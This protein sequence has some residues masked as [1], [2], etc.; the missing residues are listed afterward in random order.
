MWPWGEEEQADDAAPATSSTAAAAAPPAAPATEARFTRSQAA[1]SPNTN[2][3][4]IPNRKETPREYLRRIKTPSP[5]AQ[6][7]PVF[8]F[9]QPTTMDETTIQRLME[10]AIRATQS[11][12]TQQVQSLKK[13]DLPA[14]DKR[15]IETWILRIESAYKRVNCVDPSLKFAHLETKFEVDQ[16]PV[17]DGFLYG[18]ATNENWTRFLTYLRTR[19]GKTTKEKTQ[20]L[21]RG[22]PR[23]GRTPSQLAAVIKEK[24]KDVTI[25]D[26]RKEQLLKQLPPQVLT[27]IVDKVDSLSFED[28][29]KLA[30]AWFDQ[31]GNLKLQTNTTS[32]NLVAP[33][34]T[35]R[36]QEPQRTAAQQETPQPTFS[37]PFIDEEE[38]DINAIR[39]RQ[40]QKQTYN[41]GNSRGRGRGTFSNRGSSNTNSYGSSSSYGSG[42]SFG[43]SSSNTNNNYGNT[44]AKPK[45]VCH[46][47]IKFGDKA[48]RCEDWCLL[49]PKKQQ[50]KG[51]ARH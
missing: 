18:D 6:Q 34:P 2:F 45:N 46:F 40:A 24:T 16:D 36:Q 4:S 1:S 39:A 50:G 20:L 22:I 49:N 37:Q 43:S 31:E 33:P 14:F 3:L 7:E 47:H 9:T 35:P 42:S 30:D 17:I 8:S 10:A 15:N 44:P 12:Q 29:A 13:P 41:R 48:E 23:E 27:Q 19:Y 21:L 32:I 26:I 51:Q 5:R 25:D 11:S 28:T 38:G